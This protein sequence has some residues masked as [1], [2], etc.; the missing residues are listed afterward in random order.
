M[1]ILDRIKNL[2][3]GTVKGFATTL[4]GYQ[5]SYFQYGDDIYRCDSVQQAV[6]C[7]VSEIS[8]LEPT[9]VR[10]TNKDIIT[11]ESSDIQRLLTCPNDSMT[12]S[13]FLEKV[14]W[15]YFLNYNSFIVPTFDEW[16]DRYGD[17]KR[18]F[19]SLNPIRPSIVNFYEGKG[20]ELVIG[21]KF[22]NNQEEYKFPYKEIIHLKRNFSVNDFMG[23]DDSGNPDHRAL[24]STLKLNADLLDSLAKNLKASS[25][26]NGIL[27]YNSMLDTAA[28]KEE[29]IKFEKDLA[30]NE[31]GILATDLKNEYQPILRNTKIIDSSTLDFI[32]TKVLRS[33]GVP[34][35]V[36]DGDYTKETYEAFY[37][38]TIEPLAIRLSQEFTK[39]LFTLKEK[40]YGNQI[41]FYPKELIFMS[42]Q[43]TLEM[44]KE[45]GAAGTLYENEKRIAFGLKPLKELEGVRMQS[46]NYV[47]TAH[48]AE[49]QLSGKT[50]DSD[51]K[52]K[53][54]DTK[55][56]KN[57][58]K[59]SKSMLEI[60]KEIDKRGKVVG[61]T[62][63]EN[64]Q[65]DFL[66]R[67]AEGEGNDKEKIVEGRAIVYDSETDISGYFKEIIDNG[68]LDGTDLK[69][70]RFLVNH[71]TNEL[72]LARSRNNNKN[73][74]M[75][76]KV[77]DK[78]MAIRVKLDMENPRAVEL[79][80]AIKRGDV[81]GMSFMFSVSDEKWENEDTDYPTRH[82]TKIAQVL[83]VSA[84]TFPAYEDTELNARAKVLDNAKALLESRKSL[85]SDALELAKFKAKYGNGGK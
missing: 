21:F 55:D 38:K 31:S 4:D 41:V 65:Y 76:L 32:D 43:Q 57:D 37:Q 77:D 35:K 83:E 70:V 16:R 79:Y 72:P 5:P 17:I 12:T 6:S 44:V 60:K 69:D 73:S 34:K 36:L 64:R 50:N 59:E 53:D 40:G 68:A 74:T 8:K 25:K 45:L 13:E 7:I 63:F 19:I 14:T 30:D 18:K 10:K 56:P 47:D 71:N 28:L 52:N 78:G 29:R 23:G 48:A 62:T 3:K 11:P 22:G 27:K 39:K 66:I 46:L 80:S 58:T 2:F 51:N 20:G 9:H 54:K 67:E 84:V 26:V 61:D 82:I 1:T 42:T 49:Y 15:N 85:E 24:L 75:Q 81:S 33:F